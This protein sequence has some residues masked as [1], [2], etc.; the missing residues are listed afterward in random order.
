[1][2]NIK[3]RTSWKWMRSFYLLT[4]SLFIFLNVHGILYGGYSYYAFIILTF[5][6]AIATFSLL[7]MWITKL[8]IEKRDSIDHAQNQLTYWTTYIFSIITLVI[9]MIYYVKE[10]T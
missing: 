4:F 1:M 6:S 2:K 9:A 7:L 5:S 8:L 3:Q 10:M